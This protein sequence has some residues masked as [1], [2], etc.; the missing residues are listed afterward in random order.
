MTVELLRVR[1]SVGHQAFGV[2]LL[3][4][5]TS[6]FVGSF[7]VDQSSERHGILCMCVSEGTHTE[8]GLLPWYN[9]CGTF[10]RPCR[11]FR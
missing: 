8:G 1:S 10:V 11:A 4:P 2:P 7:D 3:R 9:S 6:D 5:S